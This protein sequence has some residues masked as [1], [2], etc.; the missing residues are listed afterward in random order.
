MSQP[1]GKPKGNQNSGP[2]N[3]T[4]RNF[5]KKEKNPKPE[6]AE[7]K[8]NGQTKPPLNKNYPNNKN[9]K[10][11]TNQSGCINPQKK[12]FKRNPQKNQNRQP[13]HPRI[14]P[15]VEDS[16]KNVVSTEGSTKSFVQNS[17][18]PQANIFNQ[19]NVSTESSTKLFVQNTVNPENNIFNKNYVLTE[20]ST[21]SLSQ[22]TVNVQNN[23]F[24]KNIPKVENSEKNNFNKNPFNHQNRQP[25][26]PRIPGN[27]EQ[28]PQGSTNIPLRFLWQPN[29]ESSQRPMWRNG[30]HGNGNQ[31]QMSSNPRFNP[32]KQPS[33]SFVNHRFP[34]PHHNG[35]PNLLRFPP[36]QF[37]NRQNHIN[38]QN[39]GAPP[40]NRQKIS[41]EEFEAYFNTNK[42]FKRAPDWI[43]PTVSKAYSSQLYEFDN[44]QELKDEMNSEKDVILANYPQEK[45]KEVERK[46]LPSPPIV[47]NLKRMKLGHVVRNWPKAYEI[48]SSYPLV[49]SPKLN[50][51]HIG[52]QHGGIIIALNHYLHSHFEDVEW[53]WKAISGNPYYEDGS[54]MDR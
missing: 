33:Q 12:H 53:K 44:F 8:G 19:N 34:N 30:S 52:D 15:K 18:N 14:L 45:W 50:S 40:Q 46:F 48:L 6:G 10:I 38:V 1:T 7:G 20:C 42:T 22:S 5:H 17:V 49:S 9:P 13:Y 26:H 25:Y 16:E 41:H 51:I 32:F 54:G 2:K 35:N 28:S 47:S 39:R 43:L 24:D 29:Q 36:N 3:N 11:D 23:I 37:P 21:K 4:N 31:A 27:V